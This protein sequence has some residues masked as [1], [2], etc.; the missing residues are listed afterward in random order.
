[1]EEQERRGR[2]HVTNTRTWSTSRD[3]EPLDD[4]RWISIRPIDRA[5]GPGLSD[6]YRRLSPESR[7]RRFLRSGELDP[8][9]LTAFTEPD[10]DGLVGILEAAGPDDGAVIAHASVQPDGHGA[11]EL[12]LAV[13]DELQGRGIGGRLMALA[14]EQARLRSASRITA[15]LFADNV[16]MRRLLRGAGLDVVADEIEAGVEE[17][18]LRIR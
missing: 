7:R 16:P 13:S 18:E 14:V 17:I 15:T 2:M 10:G 8:R 6:F 3:R 5:D 12:A 11:M 4:G 1:M 9:V